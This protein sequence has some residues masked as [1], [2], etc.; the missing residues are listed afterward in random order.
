MTAIEKL[1][2][3]DDGLWWFNWLYRQVTLAIQEECRKEAWRSPVWVKHLDV[4]F[5][6]LYFEATL[7]WERD[8]KTCPR[9]WR[10]LFAARHDRY[11]APVQYALAGLCAHINRDLPI[12]AARAAQKAHLVLTRGS[13][14]EEDYQRINKILYEVELRCVK[15]LTTGWI[16]V[17]STRMDPYDRK[18]A[19]AIVRWMRDIAWSHAETY[20][21]LARSSKEEAVR[22][23][24][25]L[26]RITEL[27]AHG[28][29][30]PTTWRREHPSSKQGS[31]VPRAKK[32]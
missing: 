27:V 17:V 12:A 31:I 6:K 32:S 26:D 29:L 24:D 1:L 16:R 2:P 11:V 28:M 25:R 19:I 21:E 3:T 14:E 22:F 9:A 8:P 4:E 10:P 23:V 20:A 13:A 7:A 18:L 15:E 5:G 30:L